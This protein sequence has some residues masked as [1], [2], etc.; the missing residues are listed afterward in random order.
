M[1]FG[2]L[3]A[4]KY[5]KQGAEHDAY[6]NIGWG[7]SQQETMAVGVLG[8]GLESSSVPP[9]DAQKKQTVL[10]ERKALAKSLGLPLSAVTMTTFTVN[11]APEASTTVAA[12]SS[13]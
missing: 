8:F 4:C 13:F 6:R 7:Y 11:T 2:A 1:T 9:A 10:A 12:T 5:T 3:S